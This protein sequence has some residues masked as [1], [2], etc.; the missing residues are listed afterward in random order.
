MKG[1]FQVLLVVF[2]GGIVWSIFKVS[3]QPNLPEQQVSPS[4]SR[5]V[6]LRTDDDVTLKRKRIYSELHWA[7]MR[8]VEDCDHDYPFPKSGTEID[9]AKAQLALRAAHYKTQKA[10][11]WHEVIVRNKIDRNAAEAIDAEG[12]EK[13]WPLG[14]R[15]SSTTRPER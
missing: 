2:L 14:N 15:P 4:I 12:S 8:A 10:K 6:D 9:Q 5:L 11:Y 3:T 13:R 7:G 1:R